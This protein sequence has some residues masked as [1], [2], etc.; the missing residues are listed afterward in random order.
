M[1]TQRSDNGRTY[2]VLV[3]IVQAGLTYFWN[4]VTCVAAEVVCYPCYPQWLGSLKLAC[5]NPNPPLA[6]ADQAPAAQ[7]PSETLQTHA[8]QNT[9]TYLLCGIN[10]LGR[11]SYFA[12]FWRGRREGPLSSSLLLNLKGVGTHTM[13]RSSS[14]PLA[15][16]KLPKRTYKETL[17]WNP[18]QD[19]I[20][21]P[22]SLSYTHIPW[23]S[24]K[25][26]D[27]A[28]SAERNI[29][30]GRT[31]GNPARMRA[32]TLSV[33]TISAQARGRRKLLSKAAAG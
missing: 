2:A 18:Y 26:D 7:L 19:V 1:S 9:L 13:T 27:T 5:E 22:L 16:T 11:N 31:P 25:T 8:P 32:N 30:G 12:S 15:G 28:Y 29:D 33:P 6:C 3:T 21:L 17:T 14:G 4:T 10:D 23:W 20:L 24:P